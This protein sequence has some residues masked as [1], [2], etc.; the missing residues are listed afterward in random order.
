MAEFGGDKAAFTATA[1]ASIPIHHIVRFVAAGPTVNIASNAAA[2]YGVGALGVAQAMAA[3]NDAV[4]VAYVGESKVVAG[5]A[6]T[7]GLLVTTNGSG[8]AAPAGSADLAIGRAMT[9]AAADGDVIR[10]LL[11]PT[12]RPLSGVA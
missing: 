6:I 1:V 7:A 2:N 3:P 5:E 10:V 4:P 11:F 9:A 8:R 12:M